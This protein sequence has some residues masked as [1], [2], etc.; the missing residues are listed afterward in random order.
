MPQPEAL[1]KS[2]LVLPSPWAS[3]EGMA[4]TQGSHSDITGP[5]IRAAALR[6]FA[7]EG[8]AAVSMRQIASEAGVQAGTI[9]P[10][11]I[12]RVKATGSTA[13]GLVG[14]R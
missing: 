13:A 11:R 9:Y 3:R 2:G 12:A 8:Y 7:A 10:L 14:L 1:R 5:R 6:L 4:R